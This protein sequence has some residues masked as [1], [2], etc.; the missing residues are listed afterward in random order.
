M[1]LLKLLFPHVRFCKNK[2]SPYIYG[3]PDMDSMMKTTGIHIRNYPYGVK[4]VFFVYKPNKF[5]V[6]SWKKLITPNNKKVKM[7]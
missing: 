5:I 2:W 6:A 3:D 4:A 7:K 1:K